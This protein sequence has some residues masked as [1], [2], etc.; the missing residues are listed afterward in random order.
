MDLVRLLIAVGVICLLAWIIISNFVQN[1]QIAKV[2]WAVVAIVL[3][4]YALATV[5]MLPPNVLPAGR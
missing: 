4:I 1:P 5:G 2:C 3:I